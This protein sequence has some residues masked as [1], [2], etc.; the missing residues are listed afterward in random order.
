MPVIKEILQSF[1]SGS[2]PWWVYAVALLIPICVMFTIREFFCWFW[3]I[4]ALV[5]RLDRLERG[6]K[7]LSASPAA[8]GKVQSF[9]R[10]TGEARE[11]PT[12]L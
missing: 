11:G 8:P 1:M 12:E 6:L 7:E 9:N 3:K 10:Q 2:Q 5:S 4:N